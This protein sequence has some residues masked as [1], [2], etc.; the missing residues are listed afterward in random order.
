MISF[1]TLGIFAT[2]IKNEKSKHIYNLKDYWNIISPQKGFSWSLEL[3][4]N[5]PPSMQETLVQ[6]LTLE[7][8][9]EEKWSL[10]PSIVVFWEMPWRKTLVG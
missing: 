1:S 4:K 9:R 2:T 10:I 7:D 3:K 6:S 8:P 5:I